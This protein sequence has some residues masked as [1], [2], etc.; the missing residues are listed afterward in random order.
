MCG[1]VA[2]LGP[3]KL[4]TNICINSLLSGLYYL[5]NRGYD[6]AGIS[7]LNNNNKFTTV[8]YSSTNE[9]NAI[10]A[11]ENHTF[12]TNDD[13]N[14]CTGIAHTRWATHGIKSA[15]NSHPH[16]SMNKKITLVH[17]GII[18][19]YKELKE[20]LEGEGYVFISST[21]TEVVSQLL[22]F[23]Y[24]QYSSIQMAIEKVMNTLI[25]TWG[26]VF[27]CSDTLNTLYCMRHGNPILISTS[28]NYECV[29]IAS[30]SS[31]LNT[32]SLNSIL[33]LSDM[34][35][36]VIAKD[37]ENSI[38]ISTGKECTKLKINKNIDVNRTPSPYKHWT[39]KEIYEQSNCVDTMGINAD[40]T[41]IKM[42]EFTN[43]EILKKINHI[44]FLGCGTSYYAGL[45]GMQY[46]KEMQLFDTVQIFD[47]AEFTLDDIPKTGNVGFILMSQSGE[48]KDLY[49]CIEMTRYLYKNNDN[50]KITTIG[51][52]NVQNSL[53]SR[54][55]DYCCYLNVGTEHA[56]ASTKSFT[57]QVIKLSFIAVWF[58]QLFNVKEE[59]RVKILNDACELSR[60]IQNTIINMDVGTEE[61]IDWFLTYQSCFIIGK[62]KCE[63]IAK[64]C[65]LK[66]KEISYIHAEGYSASSLKHGPFAL[67][68]KDYPVIML[69][70]N[71]NHFPK[72]LNAYEE[73]TS[74]EANVLLITTKENEHCYVTGNVLYIENNDTYAELLSVIPMQLLAYKISV[75]KNVN[76]DMPRNLAKV[77][78][79][80]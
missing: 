15:I 47:G 56:V 26:I 42:P 23:Y 24:L 54:E 4:N 44:I 50:N 78:T 20:F 73:I 16:E 75:C 17:N 69:A 68:E 34:D 49:R 12:V 41:V 63:S 7:L 57:A 59:K 18:E 33:E 71:N 48:T 6:S 45:I 80:E 1:I 37:N 14:V 29:R 19:N 51:V 36:A 25:G 65:S 28:D 62:G 2:Y 22:E 76:P 79:V 40:K 66:L 67:L 60:D 52:V 64:E 61:Y 32:Q 13:D 10:E 30:E 46:F 70:P 38:T 8:K 72:M 27:M 21:D 9:C 5:Q 35:Y 3:N 77:V 58:A 53:I 31:A 39:L 43:V 55:V 11:L 74:R